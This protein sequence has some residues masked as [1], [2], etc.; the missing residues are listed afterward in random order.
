MAISFNDAIN[1]IV[2]NVQN[3]SQQAAKAAS[4]NAEPKQKSA[5]NLPSNPF[6]SNPQETL[7]QDVRANTFTINGQGS[8]VED[9]ALNKSNRDNSLFPNDEYI[10]GPTYTPSASDIP[11]AADWSVW[12]I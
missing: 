6:N 2:K 1:S 3:A 9:T 10:S 7:E 11:Y 12:D 4:N 5:V 8:N